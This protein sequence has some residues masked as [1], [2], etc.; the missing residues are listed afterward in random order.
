[1]SFERSPHVIIFGTDFSGSEV[2]MSIDDNLRSPL[3]SHEA[4]QVTCFI[5]P[6]RMASA[7]RFSPRE[8]IF[9]NRV[10]TLP[11]LESGRA[12][13]TRSPIIPGDGF[14]DK[15]S[16]VSITDSEYCICRPCRMKF[17]N[18]EMR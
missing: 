14:G 13:A 9:H 10:R 5:P 8:S 4:P 18:E 2:G 11:D 17:S 3:N 1:M 12:P 15:T 6:A 16:F 7:L